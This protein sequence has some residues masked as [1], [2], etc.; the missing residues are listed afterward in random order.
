MPFNGRTPSSLP[1]PELYIDFGHPGADT[2]GL[3]SQA[4]SFSRQRR[5]LLRANGGPEFSA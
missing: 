2:L 5:Q 4:L 1:T 3:A